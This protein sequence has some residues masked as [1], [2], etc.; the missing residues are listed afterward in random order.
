MKS[1]PPRVQVAE[2]PARK[3]SLP[4]IDNNLWCQIQDI[5]QKIK[6]NYY[7]IKLDCDYNLRRQVLKN[8]VNILIAIQ[9][10]KF[11]LLYRVLLQG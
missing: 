3:E 7:Q 2:H 1:H 11:F 4:I 9:I 8:R 10:A 5:D 6:L